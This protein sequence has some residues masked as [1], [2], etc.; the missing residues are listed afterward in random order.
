MTN[1]F[2]AAGLEQ[3]APRPLADRLRP[4]KLA[5]VI[6]QAHIVG[7]DGSLTRML[8]AG[9]LPNLILWGP[10]G[11]G[12]TTIVCA[13]A[14][15]RNLLEK[16]LNR[17]MAL[18]TGSGRT[19]VCEV[20]VR[21]GSGYSITVDPCSADELY[22]HVSE[23]CDHLLALAAEDRHGY[24]IL[25]DV[26]RRTAGE[27]RLSAATLYRS[28]QR[29][30]EDGLIVELRERPAPELDD[31]RRRYYRITRRGEAA[32]RAEAERLQKLVRLARSAGIV[33]GAAGSSG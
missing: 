29:L 17:Q 31:E 15:L 1:L 10:P 4:K 25:L 3:G 7:P 22:Q 5:E 2:E 9:R 16:E 30:L 28:I 19:T 27:V 21:N 23:F 11:V 14:R 8:R 6:G 32:A 33:P 26:E 20:H 12:K 13:L 24:A 18:Q